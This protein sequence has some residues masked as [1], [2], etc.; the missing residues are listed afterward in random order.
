MPGEGGSE[1][2]RVAHPPPEL[3]RP[4]NGAFGDSARRQPQQILA[5]LRELET[6]NSIAHA[7]AFAGS[8]PARPPFEKITF[9]GSATS[10]LVDGPIWTCLVHR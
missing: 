9:T 7:A 5:W 6:I 8:S 3:R 2:C 4:S 1:V 10:D